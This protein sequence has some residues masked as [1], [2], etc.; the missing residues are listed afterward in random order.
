MPPARTMP[1]AARKLAAFDFRRWRWKTLPKPRYDPV[2]LPDGLAAVGLKCGPDQDSNRK[3]RVEV[4]TLR[5]DDKH[6]RNQVVTKRSEWVHEGGGVDLVGVRGRYAY[7]QA[8]REMHQVFLRVSASGEVRKLPVIPRQAQLIG[9]PETALPS[10]TCVTPRGVDTVWLRYGKSSFGPGEDPNASIE[11]GPI[12]HLDVR[13]AKPRWRTV[14]DTDPLVWPERGGFACVKQG[15]LL[16]HPSGTSVWTGEKFATL[17]DAPS[18]PSPVGLTTYATAKSLAD[19]GLVISEGLYLS[20]LRNGVWDEPP[21]PDERLPWTTVGNL[22]VY[23][24]TNPTTHTV[25]LHTIP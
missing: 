19:G 22:I 18:P 21:L 4:S 7:F 3:C 23:E 2:A 1:P 10:A 17:T 12:K 8:H 13:S 11:P 20:R 14:P 9:V 24:A 6:W 5:W 15:L 16:V 25:Q